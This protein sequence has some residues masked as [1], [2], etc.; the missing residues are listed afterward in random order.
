MLTPADVSSLK[1]G[2][3][4]DGGAAIILICRFPTN[5]YLFS[6]QTM[7]RQETTS[8]FVL[9]YTSDCY[10]RDMVPCFILPS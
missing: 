1:S 5:V 8:L 4:L 7:R 2:G 9:R 6:Y 10:M 3:A